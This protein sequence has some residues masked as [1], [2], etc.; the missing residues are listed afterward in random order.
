MKDKME[1]KAGKKEVIEFEVD[2]SRLIYPALTLAKLERDD[3]G[4][5]VQKAFLPAAERE[6]IQPGVVK[7]HDDV[8]TVD[9]EM[10]D[11]DLDEVF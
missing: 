3:K 7:P 6:A 10:S 2:D 8:N 9:V 1:V 5:F 11:L 4:G